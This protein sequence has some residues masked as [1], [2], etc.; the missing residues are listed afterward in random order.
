MS[1]NVGVASLMSKAFPLYFNVP[2][3]PFNANEPVTFKLPVTF[4]A[5]PDRK[6]VALSLITIWLFGVCIVTTPD[7]SVLGF[8]Q[9]QVASLDNISDPSLTTNPVA[10]TS[11]GFGAV[12]LDGVIG[13]GS[14]S[15]IIYIGYG[16]NSEA[17]L[18]LLKNSTL[19]Y[20]KL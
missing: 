9:L 17:K 2:S 14:N 5:F 16:T 3:L 15:D 13:N 8:S 1:S 19:E 6:D 10:I 7:G 11:T 20:R 18:K 12:R 4:T